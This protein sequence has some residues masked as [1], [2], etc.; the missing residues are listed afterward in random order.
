[1]GLRIVDGEIDLESTVIR[2]VYA[3][4]IF[5]AELI[6]LPLPSIQSSSRKPSVGTTSV[7]PSQRAVEYPIQLGVGS[8]GSG[9]PSMWICRYIAFT[10]YSSARSLG[11]WMALVRW[12]KFQC[13]GGLS[14]RQ[15]TCGSSRLSSA[16]RFLTSSAAH[17]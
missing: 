7:S 12:G 5:A 9:R 15:R 3:L 14:G 6:G 16:I 2:P 4:G 1:V 13:R 11:V 17:G 10:S 8:T